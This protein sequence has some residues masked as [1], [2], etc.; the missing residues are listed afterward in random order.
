LLPWFGGLWLLSWM[1]GIGGGLGVIGFGWDILLV[2]AW[3][4]V[5]LVLAMRSAL[6][7]GET[8]EM[9][10]RMNETS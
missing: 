9:M 3:S 1:G 7:A 6:D 4:V 10:G 8:S 5:V 2:A